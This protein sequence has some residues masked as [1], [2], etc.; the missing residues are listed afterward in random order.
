MNNAPLSFSSNIK[1]TYADILNKLVSYRLEEKAADADE[2]KFKISDGKFTIHSVF[3]IKK[4]VSSKI[5]LPY[6]EK[7]E[8]LQAISG[9]SS[10]YFMDSIGKKEKDTE[11]R[12]ENRPALLL[13]VSTATLINALQFCQSLEQL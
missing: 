9:N 8:G 6:L 1:F 4:S 13:E 12:R 5:A 7:N 2:V 3:Q 11:K 10:I